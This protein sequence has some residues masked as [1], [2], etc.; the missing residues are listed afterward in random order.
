MSF[1][2]VVYNVSFCVLVVIVCFVK[3]KILSVLLID[4]T[5]NSLCKLGSDLYARC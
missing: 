1:I 2:G 4:Y 5:L 3:E